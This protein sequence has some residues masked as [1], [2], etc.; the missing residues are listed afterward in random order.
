MDANI[1]RPSFSSSDVTTTNTLVNSDTP[2]TNNVILRTQALPQELQ[3]LIFAHVLTP[4]TL[5]VEISDAYS[6]PSQLS[7]DQSS[8]HIFSKRFYSR[9]IVHSGDEGILARWLLSL[10]RDAIPYLD[11]VRLLRPGAGG[12]LRRDTS[13]TEVLG[14]RKRVRDAF[15]SD[16]KEGN[17]LRFLTLWSAE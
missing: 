6:P 7:I 4:S 16:H 1:A 11:D 15:K 10:P 14:P 9:T 2:H 8:R 17:E 12:L 13:E 5:Y 3:D